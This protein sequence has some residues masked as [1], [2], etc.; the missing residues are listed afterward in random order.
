MTAQPVFEGDWSKIRRYGHGQDRDLFS[1][2]QLAYIDNN[3]AYLTCEKIHGSNVFSGGNLDQSTMATAAALKNTKVLLYL[4]AFYAWQ[5]YTAIYNMDRASYPNLFVPD[6]G[7]DPF[8][9]NQGTAAGRA[10][11]KKISDDVVN[12][13]KVVGTFVDGIGKINTHDHAEWLPAFYQTLSQLDGL[14]IHNGSPVGILEHSDGFMREDIVKGT[15]AER[16]ENLDYIL[17]EVDVNKHMFLN[18]FHPDYKFPLA[19]FL[20]LAHEKSFFR[21]FPLAADGSN[22][23]AR[24]ADVLWRCDEYDYPLGAPLGKAVKDGLY[25]YSRSFEHVD[26]WVNIQTEEYVLAWDCVDSDSDGLDDQWEYRNFGDVTIAD[27]I[28]DPDGDGATNLEEYNAGTDPNSSRVGRTNLALM[29]IASQSSTAPGGAASLAINNAI[30]ETFSSTTIEDNPWWQVDLGA[31]YSLDEIVIH[32]ISDECCKDSLSNYTVTIL[33]NKNKVVFYKTITDYTDSSTTIKTGLID[34]RYVKI[35]LNDSADLNLV[36]VQIFTTVGSFEGTM[37]LLPLLSPG[38]CV[39]VFE[40]DSLYLAE[41]AFTNELTWKETFMGNGYYSYQLINTAYCISGGGESTS[42][43]AVTVAACDSEDPAQ[44]WYKVEEDSGF[45]RLLKGSN[46]DYAL[47]VGNEKSL[48]LQNTDSLNQQQY[49]KKGTSSQILF[50]VEDVASSQKLSDVSI[51][52]NGHTLTTDS[53]GEASI[54]FIDQNYGILIERAGYASQTI[55]LS[56]YKDTTLSIQMEKARYTFGF[57]V[58]DAQT[59]ERIDYAS[60]W[61]DDM[62]SLSNGDGEFSMALEGGVYTYSI[63]K[64]GYGQ[65]SGSILLEKDTTITIVLATASSLRNPDDFDIKI[66]PNP[67]KNRLFVKGLDKRADVRYKIFNALGGVVKRGVLT[68]QVDISGLQPGVYFMFVEINNN[69]IYHDFVI[70]QY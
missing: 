22:N 64:D 28:A 12:N 3:I 42:G 5:R 16:R 47:A 55:S 24:W 14:T 34:G 13:S 31:N 25:I 40:N 70:T 9:Y 35:Q 6:D 33:D 20:V 58:K 15:V 62:Y 48:Q 68:A 63:R 43:Q 50:E 66:Y 59:D 27:S 45:Y 10:F 39:G 44:L 30:D 2:E 52:V 18:S 37:Q 41:H 26:V 19:C 57:S 46:T 53:N 1:A 32:Y 65:N 11:W 8:A 60:I 38:Q 4:Q 54:Q 51:L 17:Y 21:Y 61:I 49:W 23:S 29:G 7:M 69:T 67:V 36:E 56:L